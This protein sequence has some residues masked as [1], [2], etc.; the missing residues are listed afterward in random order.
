M[1]L[2]ELKKIAEKHGATIEVGE[3]DTYNQSTTIEAIAPDGFVW[4]DGPSILIAYR[5]K[6]EP[7][8]ASEAY[9][10][11]AQRMEFGIEKEETK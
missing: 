9:E 8:S 1:T 7:N 3:Y 4:S 2:K 11:L 5:F 10:D 6:G